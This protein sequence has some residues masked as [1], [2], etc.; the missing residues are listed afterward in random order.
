MLVL[1][2][3]YGTMERDDNIK[4]NEGNS[5]LGQHHGTHDV[6]VV[7]EKEE[8][9]RYVSVIDDES[10]TRSVVKNGDDTMNQDTD[11]RGKGVE[12]KYEMEQSIWK[13]W[14]KC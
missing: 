13:R 5:V 11:E 10:K 3:K 4:M 6:D 7:S 12:E 8:Q 9:P 14:C 2:G 1:T